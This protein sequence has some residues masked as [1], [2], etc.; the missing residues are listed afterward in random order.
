MHS[1]TK[2]AA[3]H[4][5]VMA[6]AVAGPRAL[7]ER[8]RGPAALLGATLDPHAAFLVSRGLKT[9]FLRRSATT[10][11]AAQ[12]AQ[13]LATQPFVRRVHYPGLPGHP[14][15]QLAARQMSD[16]G[17]IVTLELGGG[18]KSMR[19]FTD[20]LA[21]FAV[22]P[23][24]GSTESLIVPAQLLGSQGL[25]REAAARAGLTAGTARLSIGLEDPDDLI[26]DLRQ[27]LALASAA[28]EAK[29]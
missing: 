17:S 21:L 15:H 20:S 22:T 8:L 5:D 14:G 23:S 1:L 29:D 28:E 13:F 7:I 27:A 10:E 19:V 6:G 3:G 11:S 12:V 18:E 2:Y 25:G 16:F 24:V 26:D 9:Y 4:G